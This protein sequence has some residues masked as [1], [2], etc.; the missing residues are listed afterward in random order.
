[1]EQLFIVFLWL[2]GIVFVFFV[3][4]VWVIRI[5]EKSE[6]EMKK[7]ARGEKREFKGKDNQFVKH[8]ILRRKQ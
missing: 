7:I 3:L 8:I 5:G 1:M 6:S 2:A 4:L